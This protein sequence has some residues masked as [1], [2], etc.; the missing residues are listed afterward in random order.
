MPFFAEEAEDGQYAL[1]KQ[2]KIRSHSGF[3]LVETLVSVAIL[4]LIVLGTRQ[5]MLRA[6]QSNQTE[7]LRKNSVE[8]SQELTRRL[9]H[10][11][12]RHT[13]KTLLAPNRLALTLPSGQVVIETACLANDI[14]FQAPDALLNRCVQCPSSQRQVVR[15]TA[16]NR[17]QI[18]PGATQKPDMPSAA[19]VCFKNG[20]DPDE[21]ELIME[22]LVVDPIKKTDK[23]VSKSE[24]FLIKDTSHFSSFE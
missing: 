18:L 17:T 9:N 2:L 5:M 13:A 21:I 14:P 11:Y 1:R 22:I 4:G 20:T 19:S 24:S 3:S 15:I 7:A 16:N 23:K 6:Q 12:K 10:Y 8:V